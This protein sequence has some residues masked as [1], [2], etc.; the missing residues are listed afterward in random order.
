MLIFSCSNNNVSQEQVEQKFELSDLNMDLN[1]LNFKLP[2]TL[3]TYANQTELVEQSDSKITGLLE[4]I[5]DI[6]NAN[7]KITNVLF[8]ISFEDGVAQLNYV[9]FL[10]VPNEDIIPVGDVSNTIFPNIDW[11]RLL[12]GASCPE[13]Y[14]NNG[15][16][17]TSSCVSETAEAILTGEGGINSNGDCAEIR[18]NRGLLSVRI[19]SR[20]CD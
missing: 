15:S 4:E 6:V 20:E 14:T 2:Q 9:H 8:D 7:Q 12:N 16:C 5:D 10:D 11:D 18:F 17:S 19:C 13:G 3:F 1:R